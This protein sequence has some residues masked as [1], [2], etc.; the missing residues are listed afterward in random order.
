MQPPGVLSPSAV[1]IVLTT[2]TNEDWTAF[3]DS[4]ECGDSLES[5][6]FF[7]ALAMLVAGVTVAVM[8]LVRAVRSNS[9]AS[10]LVSFAGVCLVVCGVAC[11][12]LAI[13]VSYAAMCD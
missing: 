13:Q 3:D 4:I 11:T 2:W 5:V 6:L 9:W 1:L 12:N 8:G 7:T 10:M